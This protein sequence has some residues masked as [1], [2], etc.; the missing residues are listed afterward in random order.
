[1]ST[2]LK[3]V[4]V[5]LLLIGGISIPMLLYIQHRNEAR[6][7]VLAG[8]NNG[9]VIERVASHYYLQGKLSHG[10]ATKPAVF[11]VDTGAS[12]VLISGPI[13]RELGIKKGQT[14]MFMTAAGEAQG[15][16]SEVDIELPGL[17]RLSNHRVAVIEN[18]DDV[19]LLGMDI[20]KR[21][22]LIQSD[23]TLTI[24]PRR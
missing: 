20:L 15:Y 6:V 13:A 19:V 9:V 5:W 12:T 3:Y 1:V 22:D 21:Y 2:T 23:R 16:F 18:A 7:Q 17:G 4:T 11:M 14:A 10:A 8:D 24:K